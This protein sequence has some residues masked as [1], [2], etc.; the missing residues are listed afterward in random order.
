[1]AAGRPEKEFQEYLRKATNSHVSSNDYFV[2]PATTFLKYTIEAKS[3]IDLCI[4][5]FPK[6]II[7]TICLCKCTG[8][9]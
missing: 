7:M 3:A 1:M 9:A 2:T 8:I 4:R 6:K 5:Q